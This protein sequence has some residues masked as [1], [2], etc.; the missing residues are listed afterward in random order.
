MATFET[1][2]ASVESALGKSLDML[3][4]EGY[5]RAMKKLR[6]P[7][8]KAGIGL[9][10]GAVAPL[11]MLAIPHYKA[12]VHRAS[13]QWM[14]TP[15]GQ[16]LPDPALRTAFRRRMCLPVHPHALCCSYTT[17]ASTRPC[18][19]PLD[20]H[21]QHSSACAKG[22][23]R[24]RHDSLKHTWA[25]LIRL[26][27]WHVTVEQLVTLPAAGA[28]TTK[29]ADLIAIS[30]GGNSCALDVMVTQGSMT[31]MSHTDL[32][33]AEAD[34]CRQYKIATSGD[35]LPGGEKFY[36]LVHHGNGMLGAA[37][38]D[39]ANLILKDLATKSAVAEGTVWQTAVGRGRETIFQS[40]TYVQMRTQYRAFRACGV[41]L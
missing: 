16:F 9:N 28:T 12:L 30:P 19:T 31:S 39:F 8:Y 26:A 38:F 34:K 27:G 24:Y 18:G 17:V 22:P 4:A 23:V 11:S 33:T 32:A 7:L 1:Y 21:G 13:L 6:I 29:R 3:H 36:P 40:L 5:Q 35:A 10:H 41:T 25:K 15:F 37:A 20:V 2:A 14:L